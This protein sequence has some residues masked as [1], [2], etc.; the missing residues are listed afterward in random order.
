MSQS[1]L[2]LG[3]HANINKLYISMCVTGQYRLIRLAGQ[4]IRQAPVGWCKRG[5]VVLLL[6]Y[7]ELH[8]P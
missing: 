7:T 5:A 4:Y 1:D 8:H 6:S 3:A 2:H